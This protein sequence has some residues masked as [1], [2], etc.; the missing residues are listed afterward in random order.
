MYAE[1]SMLKNVINTIKTHKLIL[2]GERVI[3]AFSGGG[4]SVTLL[5]ILRKYQEML[6]LSLTAVHVNHGIRGEEADSDESFAGEFCNQ[7]GIEFKAFHVDAPKFSKEKGIS[8]ENAAR[9]LRME[10]LKSALSELNAAKIATAHNL[11][12]QAETVLMR[13][14]RGSS[15]Y[16]LRGMDIQSGVI[17]RPLLNI[18]R[19]EIDNYLNENNIPYVTD[20]T[21]ASPDFTR[22]RIRNVLIP[23]IKTDFNPN[24][25]NTLAKT[26]LS[27]DEDN[28]V[29]N[30]LADEA[31]SNYTVLHRGYVLIKKEAANELEVAILKRLIRKCVQTLGGNVTDFD[32]T[33]TEMVVEMFSKNT[34]KGYALTKGLK[35]ANVF[36]D[37]A[38]Y[39]ADFK[40]INKKEIKQGDFVYIDEDYGYITVSLGRPLMYENCINTCTCVF[41]CD[42]IDKQL[43]IRTREDGDIYVSKNGERIKLKDRMIDLK[44]PWFLR[45]HIP[46]VSCGDEVIWVLHSDTKASSDIVKGTQNSL[47]I[48]LWREYGGQKDRGF[49]I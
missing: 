44:I 9:V 33:H 20:S 6:G 1:Y 41:N 10:A 38:V 34:G 3:V 30:R 31:Y 25:V 8:L 12:D 27:L 21:N 18:S 49:N 24:I 43:A 29:L 14:M 22:N 17:I 5:D 37:V 2:P 4:D 36:G 19:A 46:V 47:F 28:A 13:L 40:K 32:N 35:C 39:K 15:G 26:A 48:Q 7:R 11:N 42:R 23:L 16:G 45:E